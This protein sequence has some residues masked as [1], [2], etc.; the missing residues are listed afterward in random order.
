MKASIREEIVKIPTYKIAKPSVILPS[1]RVLHRN[2]VRT[3]R[4]K[5]LALMKT[6]RLLMMSD[7]LSFLT[8]R[9]KNFIL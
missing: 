4:K 2:I 5:T 1:V 3:V 8:K 9:Q 7:Y 6:A